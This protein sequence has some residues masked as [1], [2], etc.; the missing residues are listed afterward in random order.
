LS[1][2]RAGVRKLLA[3][4]PSIGV[5]IAEERAHGPRTAQAIA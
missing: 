1:I 4:E 2:S 5:A 3:C